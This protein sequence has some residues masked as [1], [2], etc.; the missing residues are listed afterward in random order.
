MN[1]IYILQSDP[2]EKTT[3]MIQDIEKNTTLSQFLENFRDSFSETGVSDLIRSEL[4]KS[5][6]TKAALAKRA[7][8]SEVYLYQILSQRRH[9]SRDLMMCIC[10]D[11]SLSLEKTQCMLLSGGFA[12]LFI[13]HRRDA[14]I[15]YGILNKKNTYEVNDMLYTEHEQMLTH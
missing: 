1:N 14:I 4:K 9:P 8:I 10:I 6:M 5:G 3:D 13:M 2:T 12:K 7:G 11:L 15:M